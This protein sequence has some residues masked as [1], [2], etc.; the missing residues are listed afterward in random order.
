VNRIDVLIVCSDVE[1]EV[2]APSVEK[3]NGPARRR[4]DCVAHVGESVVGRV[5]ELGKSGEECGP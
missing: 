3:G 4:D 5:E 2:A 1:V